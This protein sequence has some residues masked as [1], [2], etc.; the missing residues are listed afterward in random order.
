MAKRDGNSKHNPRFSRKRGGFSNDQ[1]EQMLARLDDSNSRPREHNPDVEATQSKQA[2]TALALG[3]LVIGEPFGPFLDVLHKRL[4]NFKAK[5][6]LF[7]LFDTISAAKN[8][9]TAEQIVKDLTE[10]EKLDPTTALAELPLV[11]Y[12]G[13]HITNTSHRI[14]SPLRVALRI[15]DPSSPFYNGPQL[16]GEKSAI[17]E[18]LNP[19]NLKHQKPSEGTEPHVL[20][21]LGRC[22]GSDFRTVEG[23][24][25]DAQSLLPTVVSLSPIGE[26]PLPA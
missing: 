10:A 25:N 17:I 13:S 2:Q 18:S 5:P 22:A 6:E 24:F 4:P 9:R 7:V 26:V 3:R 12:I 16:R 15:R 1:I 19:E 11:D 8:T 14:D 21:T 20:L 23:A